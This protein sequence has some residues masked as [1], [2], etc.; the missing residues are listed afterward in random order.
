M[1]FAP[2]DTNVFAVLS[3]PVENKEQLLRGTDD[4]VA[5]TLIRL[6]ELWI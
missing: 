2:S 6:P 4:D 5:Y 1:S 3:Q